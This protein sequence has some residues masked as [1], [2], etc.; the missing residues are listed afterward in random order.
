MGG[1]LGVD[2]SQEIQR[3]LK[4]YMEVWEYRNYKE[5]QGIMEL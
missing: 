2:R 5:L 3:I 4:Q 1:S